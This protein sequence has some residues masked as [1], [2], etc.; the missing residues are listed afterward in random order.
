MFIFLPVVCMLKSY[1]C[2]KLCVKL[3]FLISLINFNLAPFITYRGKII[4]QRADLCQTAKK[5][6]KKK[7]IRRVVSHEW[8]REGFSAVVVELSPIQAPCTIYVTIQGATSL[9]TPH[10]VAISVSKYPDKL[11]ELAV[12][13]V[14]MR[15]RV[16]CVGLQ[17]HAGYSFVKVDL[18]GRL[19]PPNADSAFSAVG[20]PGLKH[21]VKISVD[22]KRPAS[23]STEALVLSPLAKAPTSPRRLSPTRETVNR[24]SQ[25]RRPRTL[26]SGT[27]LSFT[28]SQGSASPPQPPPG[29]P[30]P[31][32]I[33]RRP[34]TSPPF[35]HNVDDGAASVG[36][37]T[38][39]D[40][41][42]LGTTAPSGIV[43]SSISILMDTDD[44]HAAYGP[45]YQ[46][47]GLRREV[48]E[49]QAKLQE[50]LATEEQEKE[51]IMCGKVK[52]SL[53]AQEKSTL[54]ANLRPKLKTPVLP[55]N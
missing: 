9:T 23:V 49:K 10:L 55:N 16:E 50:L 30:S 37:I 3:S 12:D 38:G 13:A 17:L 21:E 28:N 32:S 18:V 31:Q 27:I 33:S 1:G 51:L 54:L 8:V 40:G 19:L 22:T 45:S 39:F 26:V 4:R 46:L 47:L 15:S 36:A 25:L 2:T 35:K 53:W 20:Y 43:K 42:P 41:L 24:Q 5:N 29:S 11:W 34:Q 48:V 7:M 52:A 44:V 14:E 6:P